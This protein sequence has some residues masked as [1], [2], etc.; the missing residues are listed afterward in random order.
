VVLGRHKNLAADDRLFV[1]VG[2]LPLH[3]ARG[4]GADQTA[5]DAAGA[6]G[7]RAGANQANAAGGDNSGQRSESTQRRANSAAG[8]GGRQRVGARWFLLLEAAEMGLFGRVGADHRDFVFGK[9]GLQQVLHS[10]IGAGNGGEHTD[11]NWL[12]RGKLFCGHDST[13]IEKIRLPDA[14]EN[15]HLMCRCTGGERRCAKEA[16]R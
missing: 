6:R 15:K 12:F 14:P 5:E 10:P 16:I 9:A 3:A 11:S 8:H 2:R 13:L 4:H 1:V 7:D